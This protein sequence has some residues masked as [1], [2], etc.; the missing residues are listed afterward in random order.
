MGSPFANARLPPP[1]ATPRTASIPRLPLRYG[2]VARQRGRGAG[3]IDAVVAGA[4]HDVALQ[5]RVRYRPHP[6]R[7]RG[8]WRGGDCDPVS[9]G[10]AHDVGADDGAD[11]MSECPPAASNSF[12]RMPSK[13]PRA[14]DGV[15][16]DQ[17]AGAT[18]WAA[19]PAPQPP[20]HPSASVTRLP[21]IDVVVARESMSSPGLLATWL[22]ET[23]FRSPWARIPASPPVA[24][25]CC[26]QVVVGTPST[27]ATVLVLC[28]MRLCDAVWPTMPPAGAVAGGVVA[29]EVVVGLDHCDRRAGVAGR[30]V[31]FDVVGVGVV[32]E[33]DPA[34]GGVVKHGQAAEVVVGGGVE[35]HAGVELLN[36]AI[37]ERHAVMPLQP[38]PSVRPACS[39]ACRRHRWCGR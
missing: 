37:L 35:Q 13:I 36:G 2:E 30:S 7:W 26:D 1:S 6:R 27:T 24:V 21:T 9:A 25:L 4:D 23:R 38:D 32:L 11:H 14:A 18:F 19:M 10:A 16:G 8:R 39:R 20:S 17:V 28:S 33:V 29:H 3:D 15:G 22:P 34:A 5:S 12:T 31:G